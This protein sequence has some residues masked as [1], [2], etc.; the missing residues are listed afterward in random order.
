MLAAVESSLQALS[1]ARSDKD[2]VRVIGDAAARFGF[3]SAYLIE[4]AGKLSLM[5]RVLDTDPARRD[6]WASYF[7]GDLR[8]RPRDV[9]EIRMH[10]RFVE[11]HQ[12][13]WDV[14]RDEVLKG[15]QQQKRA[16]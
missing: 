16:A 9:A 5:Q 3:R 15:Y 2:I 8:P 11:L 1:S 4:Y 12:Q 10:P 6:W 14:L 13:I 7:A